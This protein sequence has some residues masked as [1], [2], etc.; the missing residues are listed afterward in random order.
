[1]CARTRTEPPTACSPS[2]PSATVT[3]PHSPA[4]L[5]SNTA[6]CCGLNTVL[7][8]AWGGHQSDH[9]VAGSPGKQLVSEKLLY[10]FRSLLEARRVER[11]AGG[12]A[13]LAPVPLPASP[14]EPCEEQL[15][16]TG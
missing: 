2:P 14:A 7:L 12:R 13:A 8:S 4:S 15:D 9:R 11:R 5:I 16:A 10:S 6:L 3:F 1:M